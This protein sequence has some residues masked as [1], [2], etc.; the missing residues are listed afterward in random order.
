L[1]VCRNFLQAFML[2]AENNTPIISSGTVFARKKV[3]SG[4]LREI[5]RREMMLI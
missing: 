1:Q 4:I 5:S 3:I 2:S